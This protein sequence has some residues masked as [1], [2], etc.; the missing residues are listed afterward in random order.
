MYLSLNGRQSANNIE[1]TVADIGDRI[2]GGGVGEALLCYT[3]NDQCCNDTGRWFK[4][5]GADVSGIGDFYVTKG[6]NVVRLHRRNNTSPIGMYC[7]EVPDARSR[8]IITC[9]NIGGSMGDNSK[10]LS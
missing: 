7:C 4:L 8:N 6:P 10:C 9:A 5:R 2:D 3:D 1:V